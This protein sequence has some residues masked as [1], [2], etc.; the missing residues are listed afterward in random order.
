MI[1]GGKVR[2]GV[3]LQLELQK[4]LHFCFFSLR[5]HSHPPTQ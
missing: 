1:S 5:K 2:F 3:I 4:L